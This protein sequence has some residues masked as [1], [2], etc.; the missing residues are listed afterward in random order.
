[1]EDSIMNGLLNVTLLAQTVQ[2]IPE[3]GGLFSGM[4]PDHR[5]GVMLA[6]ILAVT[7]VVIVLGCVGWSAANSMHRRRLE[8]DMKRDMLDR[9]M[10]ADEVAKVIEAAPPPEGGFDR[11]MASWGKKA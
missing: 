7:L 9:G 3:S 11:W 6:I 4:D 10:S 1:L 5:F 2:S 8:A